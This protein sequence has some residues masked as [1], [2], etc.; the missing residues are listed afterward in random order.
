VVGGRV[1]PA[2]EVVDNNA[3][4]NAG[5]LVIHGQGMPLCAGCVHTGCGRPP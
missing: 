5:A 1:H 2:A 3:V 4:E